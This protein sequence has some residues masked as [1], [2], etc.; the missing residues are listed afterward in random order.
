MIMS[1]IK[2]GTMKR[3]LF[4]IF[5]MCS[6]FSKANHTKLTLQEALDNALVKAQARALGGYQ[7]KCMEMNIENLTKDSLIVMV[8]AG[9]R[10]NSL[11]DKDQD[12]LII[13][14]EII[15][16]GKQ[17]N[18]WF[19]V[20]GYC[21]Q[22]HNHSPKKMGK[23]DVNTLADSSL[24]ILA[25]YLDG[26]QFDH[27]A[28]QQAIW[29]ISDKE[30]TGKI[31]SKTDTTLTPLRELVATLKGEPLP[32]FSIASTTYEFSNGRMQNFAVWLRGKIEF[33][34]PQDNYVTLHVLNSKG[35]QVGQIVKMW[36]G[37][38]KKTYDL[39]M[40]VAGFPKGKYTVE[41]V[42]DAKRELVKKEFEI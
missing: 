40:S 5:A 38:G 9:R 4:I 12:I 33:N 39:S 19:V 10:L 42:N 14:Q 35:E 25:R 13:K 15:T 6:L 27:H 11:D 2:G 34:S 16:L 28:I 21:C 23:Y 20:T 29:A 41:I 26:K 3:Q 30:S 36:S 32:W 37:V 18:K 31:A 22:N 1:L 8:E 7:D 17:Q 24:V